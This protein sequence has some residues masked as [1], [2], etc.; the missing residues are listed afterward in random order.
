M[1]LAVVEEIAL[2]IKARLDEMLHAVDYESSITQI[3]R[4][5][6]LGDFASL[7]GTVLLTQ[8]NPIR[9][10]DLD[11]PGIPPALAYRQTFNLRYLLMPDENSTEPIDTT[12]NQAYADMVRGITQSD[13]NWYSFGGNA[14]DSE[15]QPLEYTAADGGPDGFNLPILVTYRTSEY[16]PTEARP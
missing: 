2:D 11:Y 6:R 7:S 15:F 4:P 9:V 8:S 3:V 16:D 12:L 1:S 14:I 10:P 13:P 5:T